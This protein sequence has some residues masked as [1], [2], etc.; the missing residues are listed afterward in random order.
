MKDRLQEMFEKFEKVEFKIIGEP[1]SVRAARALAEQNRFQFEWWALSLIKARPTG[2]QEGSKKGKK[3]ADRGIDGVIT[4]IDGPYKKTQRV[5]VQVKSGNVSSRDI[6]DLVGTVGREKAAVGVFITLEEPSK[7]M[8]TEAATAG[9]YESPSWGQN[10][11]KIQ[12]LTINQLLGGAR[13]QMPGAFGTF[14]QAER[15][16]EPGPEQPKLL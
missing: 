1:Q 16:K 9:F 12:I 3:G 5:L 11:P 4:F 2:G 8:L 13:V 10:Y 15:L 7:P 6:R 14:K